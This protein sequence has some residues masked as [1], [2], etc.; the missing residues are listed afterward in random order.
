MFSTSIWLSYSRRQDEPL[1][2]ED[3]FGTAAHG[4]CGSTSI[5]GLHAFADCKLLQLLDGIDIRH[6]SPRGPGASISCLPVTRCSLYARVLTSAPPRQFASVTAGL[7]ARSTLCL[8]AVLRLRG[9]GIGDTDMC[10]H[11]G[12]G[13]NRDI[14]FT[15]QNWNS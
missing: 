9:M 13:S 15:S 7:P 4:A 6:L 14:S 10:M 2:H 5:N 8:S 1:L 11:D 12:E 3:Y